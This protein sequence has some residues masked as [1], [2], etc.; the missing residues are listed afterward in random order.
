MLLKKMHVMF[1]SLLLIA[2]LAG[3]GSGGGNT[4]GNQAANTPGTSQNGASGNEGSSSTEG[5]TI[6][7]LNE[8]AVAIGV[9]VLSELLEKSKEKRSPTRR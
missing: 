7:V 5:A 2:L 8:G 1:L 4:G 3:C 6:T 9:G